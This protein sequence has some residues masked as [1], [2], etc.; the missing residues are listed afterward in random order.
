MHRY[1]VN[2]NLVAEWLEES[3]RVCL[4]PRSW[5]EDSCGLLVEWVCEVNDRVPDASHGEPSHCHVHP[6]RNMYF[7]QNIIFSIYNGE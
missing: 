5:Y 2:I 1:Y 4:L 3:E 7:T 6:L